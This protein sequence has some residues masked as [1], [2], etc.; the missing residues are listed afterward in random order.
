MGRPHLLFSVPVTRPRHVGHYNYVVRPTSGRPDVVWDVEESR[1][2]F[3]PSRLLFL[4][5]E[6]NAQMMC[7]SRVGV[8]F[9]SETVLVLTGDLSSCQR[10]DV[11]L[12]SCEVSAEADGFHWRADNIRT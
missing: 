9:W 6:I 10:R 1:A 12:L 8:F 11:L 4:P 7:G 2:G 3:G 5:R